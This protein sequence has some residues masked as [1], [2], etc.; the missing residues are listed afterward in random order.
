MGATAQQVPSKT[1]GE[2]RNVSVSFVGKLDAGELLTGSPTV[3]AVTDLT[4]SNVAVNTAI[5]EDVN[6]K[7][8]PVGMAVQFKVTG[9]LVANSPYTIPVAC[10]T[11]ATPAQTLRGKLIM[12]VESDT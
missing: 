2:D 1:G 6:G 11:D 7:D 10:G 5:L 9:G 4:F 8:V 12:E 3:D